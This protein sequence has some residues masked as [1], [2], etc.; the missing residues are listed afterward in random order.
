MASAPAETPNAVP[1]AVVFFLLAGFLAIAGTYG[2]ATNNFEPSAM[3][4]MY[5]GIGSGAVLSACAI[6]SMLSR[7]MYMIG[8]HLGLL[9]AVI[10]LVV[11]QVQIYK[12]YNVPEKKDRF[13]LFCLM[14]AGTATALLA[15]RV[16]KPKPPAKEGKAA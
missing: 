8:V 2:A 9:L 12:T 14:F 11:F 3:H 6:L 4:S 13:Q 5:S 7:K 10:L 1:V 15:L 16:L